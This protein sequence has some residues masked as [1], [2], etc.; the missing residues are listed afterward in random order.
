MGVDQPVQLFDALCLPCGD[1][2]GALVLAQLLTSCRPPLAWAF[3]FWCHQDDV[4]LTCMRQFSSAGFP[5]SLV[6]IDTRAHAAACDVG[7][8]QISHET[9]KTLKEVFGVKYSWNP[10][11]LGQF[12]RAQGGFNAMTEIQ[13]LNG[14]LLPYPTR[15]L[16]RKGGEKKAVA[17]VWVDGWLA[18]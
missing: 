18:G 1:M 12:A 17:G 8:L 2:T 9:F 3:F 11:S 7:R 13:L 6:M 5:W 4:H 10:I 16:Q 15:E 14:C